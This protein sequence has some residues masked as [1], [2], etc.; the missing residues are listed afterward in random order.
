MMKEKDRRYVE[1]SVN[2]RNTLMFHIC[3][4]LLEDPGIEN[5][6]TSLLGRS[7]ETKEEA[8]SRASRRTRGLLAHSTRP[9]K[10]RKDECRARVRRERSVASKEEEEV[11]VVEEEEVL[12]EEEVAV[13]R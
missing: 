13:W 1:E 5:E 9:G 8:F 3:P 2:K 11:E 12:E 7:H 4:L 10:G 6:R